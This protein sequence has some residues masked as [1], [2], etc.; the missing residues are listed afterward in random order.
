M[1]FLIPTNHHQG[2]RM[3]PLNPTNHQQG[4]MMSFLIALAVAAVAVG[5]IQL[6]AMAVWVSVLS[7]A[8]KA[9]LALVVIAALCI[10]L[11]F[12]WHRY[13]VSDR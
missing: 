13:K 11:W 7:F 1:F 6:G 8:L 4:Q 10:G 2:E 12:L 3:F 9:G 5:L